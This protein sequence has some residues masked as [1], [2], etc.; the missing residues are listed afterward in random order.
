MQIEHTN[1]NCS[2]STWSPSQSTQTG[3]VPISTGTYV[4]A[5]WSPHGV[6]AS[7]LKLLD[8]TQTVLGLV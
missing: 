8:S 2:Q 7:M 6:Q 3:L 5:A 1:C 4:I